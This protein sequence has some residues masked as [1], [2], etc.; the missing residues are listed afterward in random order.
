MEINRITDVALK[1][2]DVAP[3]MQ[4]VERH[5]GML[6]VH[7]DSQADVRAAGAAVL[8]ALELE[9]SDRHKPRVS[10]TNLPTS[11]PA[12]TDRRGRH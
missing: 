3:G 11:W 4:I 6:E 10:G 1:S 7:S 2:T 8:E 12:S 9:E 5:F